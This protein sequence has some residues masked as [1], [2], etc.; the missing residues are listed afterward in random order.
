VKLPLVKYQLIVNFQPGMTKH[1][2]TIA[3]E[4]L[5][6]ELSAIS[7]VTAMILKH[8]VEPSQSKLVKQL[9]HSKKSVSQL[10]PKPTMSSL[11][12]KLKKM[13]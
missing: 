4:I 10:E 7:R 1:A 2:N 9:L 13:I 5:H 3:L 11:F 6:Q 8:V 12:I